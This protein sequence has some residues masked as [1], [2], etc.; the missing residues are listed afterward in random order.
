MNYLKIRKKDHIEL[1]KKSANKTSIDLL[2]ATL[3]L[4]VIN[5]SGYQNNDPIS[6]IK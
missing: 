5:S 4:P 3:A 1:K 2:L 6:M